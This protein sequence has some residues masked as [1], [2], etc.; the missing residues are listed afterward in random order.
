MHTTR[1]AES[2]W[3]LTLECIVT[4]TFFMLLISDEGTVQNYETC[5]SISIHTFLDG[6]LGNLAH[7]TALSTVEVPCFVL[8]TP[9]SKQYLFRD[10]GR[11]KSNCRK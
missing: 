9:L 3:Y 1:T 11:Q 8:L 4:C 2:K 10:Q 7:V 5:Q 6:F